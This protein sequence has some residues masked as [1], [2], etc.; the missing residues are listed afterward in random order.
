MRTTGK[1]KMTISIGSMVS[2]G[3]RTIVR[4]SLEGSDD[5]WVSSGWGVCVCAEIK[6]L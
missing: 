6:I 5:V 3:K 2:P 4:T 1:R